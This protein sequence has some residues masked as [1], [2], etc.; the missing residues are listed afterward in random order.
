[1]KNFSSQFEKYIFAI[2]ITNYANILYVPVVRHY[3]VL[4]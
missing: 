2:Q 4:V 1:M 3:C